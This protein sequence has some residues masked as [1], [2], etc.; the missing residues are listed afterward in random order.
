MRAA[1]AVAG[2]A[3]A[4]VAALLAL[5]VL[6]ATSVEAGRPLQDWRAWSLAGPGTELLR[7]DWMQNYPRLLTRAG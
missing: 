3:T 7:F 2:G 5:S 4:V 1:D 6:G